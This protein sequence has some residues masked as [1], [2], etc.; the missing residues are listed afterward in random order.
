MSG[1]TICHKISEPGTKRSVNVA[2]C[3]AVGVDVGA[4][5]S[6]VNLSDINIFEVH[7]FDKTC[8]TIA[9]E[10]ARERDEAAK[11]R[12]E[13]ERQARI[14]SSVVIDFAGLFLSTSYCFLNVGLML[15]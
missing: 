10:E 1:N 5:S 6:G 8:P 14:A 4:S 2:A 15:H 3:S 11:K 13:D 9:A 12:A 7:E